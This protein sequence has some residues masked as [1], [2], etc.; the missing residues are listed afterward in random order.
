MSIILFAS[1]VLRIAGTAFSILLLYQIGDRR[2]AFLTVTLA[3]MTSRQIW[4][5]QTT[6]S[7][8]LS[9]LPG[10]IVS[11]FAV[12]TVYYLSQYVKEEER[13]KSELAATNEQLRSFK[14]AVEQAGHAILLTD[15]DGTIEYANP[16]TEGVTGYTPS[17][18]VGKTPALWSSETHDEALY[19]DLWKTITA[20]DIWD[21]EIVNRRRDGELCWTDVTIAPVTDADDDIERFVAVE[22][23]VTDRKEREMRIKDQNARLAVLNTTNEVIRDVNRELLKTSSKSEVEQVACEQFANAEPY[24]SAWFATRNVATDTF[25]AG[26]AI[27]IE[28]DRLNG[29]V[30]SINE[31]DHATI[32]AQALETDETHVARADTVASE[33][34][35]C[36]CHGRI[37]ADAT[38]AVPLCYRDAQYGVLVIHANNDDTMEAIDV[39]VLDELGETIAYAMTAIESQRSLLADRV[40]MLE[41]DLAA[42][43][44][45]VALAADLNCEVELERVSATTVEEDLTMY[46]TVRETTVDNIGPAIERIPELDSFQSLRDGTESL[47]RLSVTGPS[48]V[49]TLATYGSSVRSF[50][51]DNNGGVI[52]ATLAESADVRTVVEAV[53]GRHP[54]TELVSRQECDRTPETRGQFRA[55]VEERTTDRQFEA[56]QLAHFGGYFEWPRRLSGTELAENMDVSQSTYLQHLRAGQRKLFETFFDERDG[57]EFAPSG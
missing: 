28:E 24:D 18:V 2:F 33:D 3:L 37:D 15:P 36:P 5:L 7:A 51:V 31:A 16:A 55:T 27:G 13:I 22:A 57:I 38:F 19:E 54:G 1:I 30:D 29:V 17:E 11:V 34:D 20:G 41:F 40:T 21:G 8:G 44:P 52:Q 39:S 56:L 53:T 6:G 9:E 4:T 48:I 47:I 45:L 43:D 12:A 26:S 50:V 10:L 49:R 23:D 42:D 35:P 14:E 32:V 46:V 25:R